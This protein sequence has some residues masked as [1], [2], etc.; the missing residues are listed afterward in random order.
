[1]LHLIWQ[2]NRICAGE[3]IMKK[4]YKQPVLYKFGTLEE[5]IRGTNSPGFNVDFYGE[6]IN[7]SAACSALPT[8]DTTPRSCQPIGPGIQNSGVPNCNY[9]STQVF[10]P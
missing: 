6:T 5:F 4:K 10:G 3:S 7:C 2:I 1:M 8:G 9:F